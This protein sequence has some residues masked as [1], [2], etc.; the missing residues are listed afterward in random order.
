MRGNEERKAEGVFLSYHG[1]HN[2]S[3]KL[4]HGFCDFG[5]L[6]SGFWLLVFQSTRNED[7]PGKR[8]EAPLPTR[9]LCLI[10]G[11]DGVFRGWS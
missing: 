6:L 3:H 7:K 5:S 2:H 8:F 11:W 1:K 4:V 10:F 9:I